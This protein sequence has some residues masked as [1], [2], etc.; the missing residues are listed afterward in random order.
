MLLTPKF[1]ERSELS[2]F[3]EEAERLR[4]NR[5]STSAFLPDPDE[6][7]LSVNSLEIES[8]LEIAEYYRAVLQKNNQPVAMCIHKV[9]RF[10]DA[11]RKA[12]CQI[13]W[14]RQ[15]G[16]YEYQTPN[17]TQEAAYRQ[18][19]VPRHGSRRASP[20]H[21]GVEFVEV[22]DELRLKRFAREMAKRGRFHLL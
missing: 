15:N 16:R 1:T 7:Y 19:P 2:R 9:A 5:P 10:N 8:T 20:S 6:E 18:R 21:S 13:T 3:V 11:G 17:G 4:N 12:E 14:S 22:L